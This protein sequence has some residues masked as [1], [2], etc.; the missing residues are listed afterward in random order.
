MRQEKKKIEINPEQSGLAS[1]GA[2]FADLNLS[3]PEAATP[4][5]PL[6]PKLAVKPAEPEKKS[7]R[8]RV[9][10]RKETAHRGGKTVIIVHDFPPGISTLDI[11][12]IG[13]N[14]KN[15]LGCGGTVREREIEIQ[16]NHPSKI[17][18]FLEKE[19]FRVVGVQDV[20]Q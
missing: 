16:G 7:K 4:E 2:A 10:L 14:L 9:V 5:T 17:R 6:A 18:E 15:S 19:G 13:R 12:N 1:L 11:E 20:A 8:G 3:L